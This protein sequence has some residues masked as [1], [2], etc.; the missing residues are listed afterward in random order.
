MVIIILWK[1]IKTGSHHVWS[2]GILQFLG[3]VYLFP[4]W[5]RMETEQY[6]IAS[7]K[8]LMWR[9]SLLLKIHKMMIK[10]PFTDDLN[11]P[12]VGEAIRHEPPRMPRKLETH[13]HIMC[14]SNIPPNQRQVCR[15]LN[16]KL[17]NVTQARHK[18]RCNFP[19]C[20]FPWKYVA[21]THA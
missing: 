17:Y 4:Q 6:E 5:S 2:P 11:V 18:W 10:L 9:L 16:S 20:P 1:I 21:S 13:K 12:Y 7:V 15:E 3:E 14:D 8:T 19:S